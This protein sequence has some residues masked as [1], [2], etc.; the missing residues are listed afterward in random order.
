MCLAVPPAS[1]W[2]EGVKKG[3]KRKNFEKEVGKMN[4]SLIGQFRL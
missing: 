4:I 2:A 1:F 3:E